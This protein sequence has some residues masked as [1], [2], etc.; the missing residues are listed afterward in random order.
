MRLGPRESVAALH[1]KILQHARDAV[2]VFEREP[3]L[4]RREAR[5]EF[6]GL[7]RG[8]R[9]IHVELREHARLS[10]QLLRE[11][12]PRCAVVVDAVGF[13]MREVFRELLAG[14]LVVRLFRQL[15]VAPH[16]QDFFR[17][18][19]HLP[20]PRH[21]PRR[22]HADDVFALHRHGEI[23]RVRVPVPRRVVHHRHP[24]ALLILPAVD[25]GIL[26]VRQPH[27]M[28]VAAAFL[29]LE[30]PLDRRRPLAL[31][32]RA[33]ED[34][35]RRVDVQLHVHRRHRERLAVVVEAARRR[36]RREARH[37]EIHARQVADGVAVFVAIQPPQHHRP[38]APHQ[39]RAH[40]LRGHPV[41]RRRDLRGV[42]LL[43]LFRRHLVAVQHIHHAAPFLL[44]QHVEE[45][46][47]QPRVHPEIALLLFRP[48]ALHAVV[49]E[50]RHHLL[51]KAR[52]IRNRRRLLR[53]RSGARKQK[54][55]E[56]TTRHKT[57]RSVIAIRFLASRFWDGIRQGHD[58]GARGQP[59]HEMDHARAFRRPHFV[60]RKQR[61]IL[62]KS[63][64]PSLDF[65]PYPSRNST[66]L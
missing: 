1:P 8:Q 27:A 16:S 58:A 47:R 29:R 55:E 38:V 9:R 42:R 37:I 26:L 62:L 33:I 51:R 50:K 32:Q 18:L 43:L 53:G 61:K 14:P 20:A 35:P 19:H 22:A 64:H 60:T 23:A 5:A 17:R 41:H 2:G 12:Q 36:V 24:L 15:L 39:L 28:V 4:L 11:L 34:A 45:V 10:G 30:A 65:L 59:R 52:R 56:K 54:R 21:P 49:F 13:E 44:R 6:V 63:A 46:L 31:H 25:D 57:P 48:V 66:H 3:G 7:R 40:E